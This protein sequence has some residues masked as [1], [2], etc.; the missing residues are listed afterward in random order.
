MQTF[1]ATAETVVAVFCGLLFGT[2][3]CGPHRMGG[4]PMTTC[5]CGHWL[6][7]IAWF[8]GSSCFLLGLMTCA[9]F[10]V[11]GRS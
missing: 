10:V 8:G 7:S 11:G 4:L 1:Y 3:P 9:L 6:L 2:E 5:L